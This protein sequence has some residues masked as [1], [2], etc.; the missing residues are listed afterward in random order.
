MRLARRQ[1]DQPRHDEI[2]ALLIA[3]RAAAAQ[4]ELDAALE[5]ILDAAVGLLGGDE[6]SIQLIDPAT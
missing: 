5:A 3:T 6:G 2:D 1:P 4:T